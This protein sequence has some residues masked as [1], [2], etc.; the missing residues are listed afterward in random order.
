MNLRDIALGI[1]LI[2]LALEKFGINV[3]PG[4]VT[5]VCLLIAGVLIFLNR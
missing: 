2:L 1:G 3:I 4:W 5:G